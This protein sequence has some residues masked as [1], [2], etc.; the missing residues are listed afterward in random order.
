MHRPYLHLTLSVPSHPLIIPIPSLPQVTE[1][2]E[3]NREAIT[4]QRFLFVP[5]VLMAAFRE[6][7]WRWADMVRVC[8]GEG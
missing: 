8:A 1:L 5:G 3:R 4:E 7:D 2:L 6:G